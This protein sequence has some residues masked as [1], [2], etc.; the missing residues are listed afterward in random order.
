MLPKFNGLRI[1]KYNYFFCKSPREVFPV[2]MGWGGVGELLHRTVQ[3]PRL[4]EALPSSWYVASRQPEKRDSQKREKARKS[5]FGYFQC[6][7]HSSH[8]HGPELRVTWPHLTAKGL[9]NTS[10]HW[11]R[12]RAKRRMGFGQLSLCHRPSQMN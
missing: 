12:K 10:L 6:I 9:F 11:E 1:K 4:L 7:H 3:G 2:W 5:N 8:S